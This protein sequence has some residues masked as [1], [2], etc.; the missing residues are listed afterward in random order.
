[1]DGELE[2][3][4]IVWA[5]GFDAVTGALTRMG[6]EGVGGQSLKELWADGPRTYLGV[7]SPGFPNFLFA[8]GPHGTYGNVPRSTETHVEFITGLLKHMRERGYQRIEPDESAEEK[9]TDHV[10][11]VANEVLVADTAWYYGSNIPGKAKRFL[12]YVGGLPVYR[13]KLI[14][15]GDNEYDGFVFAKSLT[16]AATPSSASTA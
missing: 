3:D 8:G 1:M 16:S 6:I 5:T 13:K 9:W 12:F 2:F 14:E 7:Q 4:M 10:Y 15:V 11:D